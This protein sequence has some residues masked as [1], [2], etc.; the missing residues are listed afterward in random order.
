MAA[1]RRCSHRRGSD[2]S[3]KQIKNLRSQLQPPM[4]GM[5]GD[6]RKRKWPITHHDRP[7]KFCPD[8]VQAASRR[9]IKG[10]SDES[11]TRIEGCIHFHRGQHFLSSPGTENGHAAVNVADVEAVCSQQQTTPDRP[12]SFMLPNMGASCG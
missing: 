7:S 6:A 9:E 4:P 12:V 1:F 3:W 8:E 2:D 5:M 11:R 10:V